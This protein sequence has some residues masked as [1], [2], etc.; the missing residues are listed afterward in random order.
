MNLFEIFTDKFTGGDC[1]KRNVILGL[2][3]LALFQGILPIAVLTRFYWLEIGE[4]KALDF[5]FWLRGPRPVPS[6]VVIV[7]ID[8]K[9]LAQ[10]YQNHADAWPWGRQRWAELIV[11]LG[12]AGS[13]SIIFDISFTTEEPGD[14]AG[15]QA[16][17]AALKQFPIVVAGSYSISKPD[18][19]HYNRRYRSELLDNTRYWDDSYGLPEP[20]QLP[21]NRFPGFFKLVPPLSIFSEYLAGI[22]L[23]EV[24]APDVDGVFRTL[25]LIQEE[26]VWPEQGEGPALLIPP[27]SVKGVAVFDGA[28]ELIYDFRRSQISFA[29]RKVAI[30]SRGYFTPDYYGETPFP[31]YSYIDLAQ[32]KIAPE[33]FRNKLVVVGF[34]RSAT[35]LYDL[36]PTPFDPSASGA[37]LHATVSG[38]ILENR[39]LNRVPLWLTWNINLGL[40]LLL[41]TGLLFLKPRWQNGTTLLLVGGFNLGNYLL[42]VNG[43][44][45]DVFYPNLM[46]AGMMLGTNWLRASDEYRER[47]RVEGHFQRYLAPEVVKEILS[48]PEL[49][50]LGGTR[51]TITVLFADLKGFTTMSES[52]EPERVVELLNEYLS[53]ATEVVIKHHGTLDKYI[54]D[55]IVALFGAPLPRPN[56]AEEAVAAAIE[57]QTELARL[58]TASLAIQ[59][60]FAPEAGVGI[61]TGPVLIGNIGSARFMNYTAIGDTV[62]TAARLQAATRALNVDIL[63]TAET[64]TALSS[65]FA[66]KELSAQRLKG[67]E[68]LVAVYQVLWNEPSEGVRDAR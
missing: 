19:G 67:K 16:M 31:T 47:V 25:S 29:K 10:V 13:K 5:R 48:R 38:N 66:I 12:K 54:G 17:V 15:D 36:R 62:N 63:I 18:F 58:R 1:L 49:Q 37:E 59:R 46:M 57:I 53:V 42:F 21:L 52:N 68:E 8:E 30:D 26:Q 55:A 64:A 56:A 34:G 35:G 44:W 32:G 20:I 43:I 39:S 24:G 2:L 51:Q 65:S 27:I 7:S 9:S 22:G 60:D 23:M 50:R 40:G 61:A 11:T 3:I 33:Q 28:R 6:E 45:L 4:L 41:I 14:L